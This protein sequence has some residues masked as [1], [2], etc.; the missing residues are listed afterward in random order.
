MSTYTFG[1][2]PKEN[3]WKVEAPLKKK[4]KNKKE[5]N[6]VLVIAQNFS[7]IQP[8][9]NTWLPIGAKSDT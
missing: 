3:V 6:L 1:N 8:I 4:K 2:E 9:R 7:L 5:K